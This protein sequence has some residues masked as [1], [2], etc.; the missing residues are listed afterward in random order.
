[1]R[2]KAFTM[3][4]LLVVIAFIAIIA[5]VVFPLIFPYHN[6]LQGKDVRIL[7]THEVDGVQYERLR[8]NEGICYDRTG[9][10]VRE[11]PCS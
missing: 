6:P 11:V 8:T 10:Q 7:Y 2:K 1:M 5:A 3:M 9:N 4:E